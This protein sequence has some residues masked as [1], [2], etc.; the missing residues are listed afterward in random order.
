MATG[1]PPKVG[2]LVPVEAVH[3]VA[4]DAVFLQ[5]HGDGLRGVE[6]RVALSA[7]LGVGDE[8]LLELIGEA[9]VIHHQSAGLV[10]KDAV[11][12]G[13]GLHETVA[14]HRFVGIHR[15]QAGRVKAGQ[16][17]VAHDHDLEEVLGVLETV[18]QFAALVL[19]ADA[20]ICSAAPLQSPP[21]H[22]EDCRKAYK[23][24]AQGRDRWLGVART[25]PGNVALERC[26]R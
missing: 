25:S 7:A 26:L 14:L 5:H 9:E 2:P 13:D 19:A 3:H 6:G 22:R 21:H 16:P 18:G 15:V 4:G 10:A 24:E 12:T 11:H 1:L 23:C 17:H 20:L 8:R